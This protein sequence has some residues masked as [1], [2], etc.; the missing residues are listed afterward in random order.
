MQKAIAQQTV[1]KISMCVLLLTWKANSVISVTMKT[2]LS[3]VRTA[4]QLI[5]PH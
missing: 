1:T 4:L 5:I 3:P 2:K